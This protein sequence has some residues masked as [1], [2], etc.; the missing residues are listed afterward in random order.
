MV[1]ELLALCSDD[2]VRNAEI[3]LF[4]AHVQN[5]LLDA[6]AGITAAEKPGPRTR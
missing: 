1:R 3:N 5:K 4:F 2:A 6:V